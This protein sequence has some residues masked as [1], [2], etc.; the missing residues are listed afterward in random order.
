MLFLDKA[1]L[2]PMD[3]RGHLVN[4][5]IYSL[6][7]HLCHRF[8]LSLL[9]FTPRALVFDLHMVGTSVS[10]F[11]KRLQNNL[12]SSYQVLQIGPNTISVEWSLNG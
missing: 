12:G 2:I 10:S 6:L 4:L 1:R 5:V 7:H 11:A 9:E 8:D 3:A